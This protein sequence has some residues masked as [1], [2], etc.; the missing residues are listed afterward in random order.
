MMMQKEG[1]RTGRATTGLWIV[2]SWKWKH[3]GHL[4]SEFAFSVP[5]HSKTT[6]DYCYLDVSH[7]CIE[8][9]INAKLSLLG[10]D[11]SVHQWFSAKVQRQRL[12]GTDLRNPFATG[13]VALELLHWEKD[14][15]SAGKKRGFFSKLV[16]LFKL[17][18]RNCT[19]STFVL[20]R[21]H[22]GWGRLEKIFPRKKQLLVFSVL[23]ALVH[24]FS[25][26]LRPKQFFA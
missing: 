9:Q 5:K 26:A 22:M 4:C 25:G 13:R 11:S 15:T 6:A 24:L 16:A 3:C 12:S 20:R 18:P 14:A 8:F 23:D 21:E 7:P 1:H 10:K 2:S 19:S 17:K